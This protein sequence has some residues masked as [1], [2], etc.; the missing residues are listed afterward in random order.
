[1][2]HR[3]S[4]RP[5]AHA[6]V[7]TS[8]FRTGTLVKAECDASCDSGDY[9]PVISDQT[10]SSDWTFSWS[11]G[12]GVLVSIGRYGWIDVGVRYLANRTVNWLAEG[13]VVQDASGHLQ[14]RPRHSPVNLVEITLGWTFGP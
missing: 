11:A 6:T 9:P 4:F 2:A 14:A 10:N 5:Y 13:D 7:G 1:M 8:W 12:G 3:G